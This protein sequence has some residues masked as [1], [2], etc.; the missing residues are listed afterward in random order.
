MQCLH[1]LESRWMTLLKWLLFLENFLKL[2]PMPWWFIPVQETTVNSN[3]TN[4]EIRNLRVKLR[5]CT[6]F[7]EYLYYNQWSLMSTYPI[8]SNVVTAIK[9][10]TLAFMIDHYFIKNICLQRFQEHAYIRYPLLK[11]SAPF[12][13]KKSK[14]LTRETWENSSD[15]LTNQ[16]SVITESFS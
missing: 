8:E 13:S 6:T 14:R 10:F 12:K 15:H 1:L 11:L 9:N 3:K 2:W 16:E 5:N 7:V 4:G